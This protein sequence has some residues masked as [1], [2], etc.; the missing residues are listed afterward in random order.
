MNV[1]VLSIVWVT[2]VNGADLKLASPTACLTCLETCCYSTSSF[3]IVCSACAS[4]CLHNISVSV[5][6]F[7]LLGIV[8]VTTIKGAKFLEADGHG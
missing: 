7:V 6:E 8:L 1:V 3:L 2:T 4:T 5:F